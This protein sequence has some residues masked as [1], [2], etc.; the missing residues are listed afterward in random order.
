MI[1]NSLEKPFFQIR[2]RMVK[3]M[4]NVSVEKPSF[5]NYFPALF[6][7]IF[8]WQLNRLKN[9]EQVL[10]THSSSTSQLSKQPKKISIEISYFHNF[11]K[12]YSLNTVEELEELEKLMRNYSNSKC[13]YLNESG[14]TPLLTALKFPK[15]QI[16]FH[17]CCFLFAHY[18][19]LDNL[20]FMGRFLK[21]F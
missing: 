8:Q 4:Q 2:E 9:G 15:S 19:K 7:S 13:L 21:F 18:G 17:Y 5:E 14:D 20:D 10:I 11:L 3:I 6:F 1:I 12:R 16:Y